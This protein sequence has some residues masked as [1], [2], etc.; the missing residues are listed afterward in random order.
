[1][2]LRNLIGDNAQT[3]WR[4]APSVAPDNSIKK[5]IVIFVT[6]TRLERVTLC[7][8]VLKRPLFIVTDFLLLLLSD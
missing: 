1:M 5:N 4:V 7:L 3:V 8:E 6:P 2:E